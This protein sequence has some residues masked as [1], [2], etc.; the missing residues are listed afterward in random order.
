MMTREKPRNDEWR[1]R[2]AHP[3]QTRLSRVAEEARLI[4]V[5]LGLAIGGLVLVGL[6]VGF[7]E[8]IIAG[9]ILFS[10]GILAEWLLSRHFDYTS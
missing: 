7:S 6:S 4:P 8:P 9:I 10:F 2:Y 5:V 3:H 1:E